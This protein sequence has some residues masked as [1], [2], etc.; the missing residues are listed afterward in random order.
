MTGEKRLFKNRIG[1]VIVYITAINLQ[2][3]K[4]KNHKR[5]EKTTQEADRNQRGVFVAL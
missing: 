2:E 5:R 4:R 1:F 3:T